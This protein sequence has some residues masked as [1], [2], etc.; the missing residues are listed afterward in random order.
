MLYKTVPSPAGGVNYDKEPHIINPRE[1]TNLLGMR[2][3]K[4]NVSNF[5]GWKTILAVGQSLIGGYGTLLTQFEKFDGSI[6][7]VAA[8]TTKIYRYDPV[9]K[10][11]MDMSGANVFN[12]T[13]DDPWFDFFYKNIHYVTNKND[14]LFSSDLA[15]NYA[16]V[17]NAPKAKCGGV[18][19]DHILAFNYN[20]GVDHPQGLKWSDEGIP[21]SW[22]ALP[23]NS[24]GAFDL[25]DTADIGIS[26]EPLGSDMILYKDR[27]IIPLTWVGGNEV[28]SRRQAIFGVGLVG[29]YGIGNTGDEHVIMGP[30][31]FYLYD[32]GV[33]VNDEFAARIRRA[34]FPRLNPLLK[35]R[36]RTLLIEETREILFAYCTIN[37]SNDCDEFVVFNYEDRTWYGP[38]PI[39]R[40]IS[41]YGFTTR[42]QLRVVDSV[43]DIVDTVPIII[44]Q[45]PSSVG[46]PLNLFVDSSGGIFA[47]DESV[48]NDNGTD[49]VRV[50]ET[51]DHFLGTEAQAENGKQLSIPAGSLF[52]V[53]QVNLEVQDTALTSTIQMFL[54]HRFSVHE[55]TTYDGPY[56]IILIPGS[57]KIEIPVRAMGRW[58]R[59]KFILPGSAFLDLAAYQFEFSIAGRK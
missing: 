13:R 14:G 23:S 58:F 7:L 11:L 27:T 53:N 43:T 42:A 44:D 15:A 33:E 35:N 41:M 9:N 49:L 38:W 31:N 55:P 24:A 25:D 2:T 21:T 3:L 1:W 17:A 59:L 56:N 39:A 5:P 46:G 30:D 19:H 10:T 51:G 50:M 34:V 57:F 16:T 37:A 18:L 8:G 54:G 36:S 32:G 20:D 12:A 48:Q 22:T 40:G 45:Y 6:F 26:M 29:I 4:G 28:F 52:N 47:I